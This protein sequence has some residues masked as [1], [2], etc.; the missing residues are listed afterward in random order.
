MVIG[1][2]L[3]G[4]FLLAFELRELEL[5]A[6]YTNPRTKMVAWLRVVGQKEKERF[7][8]VSRL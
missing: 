4:F 7:P 2:S 1:K 3:F 5:D 6:S 8:S